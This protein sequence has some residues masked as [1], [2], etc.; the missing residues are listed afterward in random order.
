VSLPEL[1]IGLVGHVDHGKTTLTKRLTG[2]WTDRH[3]EEL[4][5]GITI[6]LG[7]AD[8]TFYKCKDKKGN[9]FY[10]PTEKDEN[11]KG[12]ATKLRS[13][14]FVDAPGHETLMAT[15]LSGASIMDGAL[16]LVSASEDC[17]QPQTKEHLMALDIVGIRNIIIVQNKIDL[18]TEAQA[19]EN[20]K[21]IQEFVK[22][23]VAENAPIIP[24]SAELGTN[25][26]SLIETIQESIPTAES[27]KGK[28]PRMY[29][30]RSFDINKPGSDPVKMKGGVIGGALVEGVLKVGDE[31]DIGPSRDGKF[32]ST[33]IIK[34]T[35]G[36][37]EVKV[38]ERGG[39]FGI[40][41]GLDPSLTKSD[42]MAGRI[43]GNRG[44]LTES[45][46]TVSMEVHLLDRAVGS[47]EE[48]EIKPLSKHEPLM[49]NIGTSTNVGIVQSGGKKEQY[50][51]K[52]KFPACVET[53]GRITIARRY[54]SRWRLIGYGIVR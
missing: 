17:P 38:V 4:K 31:I 27:K 51:F 13:V 3:S 16:L 39:T 43:V 2:V 11:C 54:G 22:G 42:K 45:V 25:I 23:T 15:M 40:E 1:T 41:T 12:N 53:G 48:L 49:L 21:Q 14:S 29:I 44:S 6:R 33:E 35:S 50:E 36:G 24:V 10:T 8:A 19:I 5:R 47:E 7:Y 52:F 9:V 34:L 32:V 20:Y 26:D 28:K 30:A 18:V 46:K 37:D